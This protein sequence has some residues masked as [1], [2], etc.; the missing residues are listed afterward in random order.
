MFIGTLQVELV[1]PGSVSLKDKR[2]VVKSLK[3]RLH[4]RHLVSVAEV[5]ALDHQR[6]AVLGVAVVAGSSGRAGEVLDAVSARL[7]AEPDAEVRSLVRDVSP[8]G[9]IA[10][11][12]RTDE[13]E[14][15]WTE[16]ERREGP[17]PSHAA[18]DLEGESA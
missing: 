4:R 17:A 1:V 12:D 18:A 5:D 7:R 13:G 15:L 3:D 11:E 8:I 14:P 6:L 2:R 16:D 10:R 9:A